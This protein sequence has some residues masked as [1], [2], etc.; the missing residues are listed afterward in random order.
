MRPLV[1]FAFVTL[2]VVPTLACG[3]ANAG[4]SDGGTPDAAAARPSGPPTYLTLTG[5]A[6]RF[7]SGIWVSGRVREEALYNSVLWTDEQVRDYESGR[8][9]FAVDDERRIV[10][11]SYG[12]VEARARHFGDQGCVILPDHTDGVFFTP[13]EVTS[14]LPDAASTPWPMGDALPDQPMADDVDAELLAEAVGVFFGNPDD[15]RAAFLVVHRGRIVAEEYGTG[16]H[17]D[18]QLESWSMAKSMTATLVGRL[19]QMGNLELWQ[20]APVPAWQNTDG[21]PRA[22]IRVAD[23]LRMSSGL[24]FSNTG[25]TPE[26]L[27]RSFV[28]GQVD[29]RL[30]YVAPIDAFAFSVSRDAEF[31]PNTVGRYRNSDPWTLGYIVRRTV[32]NEL[33]EE[34]LTWPQR[35]LF[36]EIGIRRFTLETDPYGNFLLTGYN[37]GTARNWA[38]FGLLYLQRGLWNGRRLLTEEFVDFVS[39]PAPAW[40]RPYYG[41]L[42]W[43]NSAD[44]SGRGGR[45][46]SLPPDTYN[47]SGAGGQSTYIIPSRELVIVVQSHRSPAAHAPD[48]LDREHEALGLAVKAVDAS[49]TW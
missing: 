46:P 17:R 25:A 23:L 10:T 41:G 14:A 20:P 49:W 42:F 47:A 30:G 36:D 27:A 13:R 31:P 9:A 38:R 39:S 12:G 26:Q 43:L 2:V 19:I 1:P 21:D 3:D 11:A 33:G 45:I 18:M 29:H 5:P 22:A 48:R 15:N 6:K 44:E 28:P 24:R 4:A 35:S 16:A 37:F 32:E 7:C 34:Y 8:L 40:D